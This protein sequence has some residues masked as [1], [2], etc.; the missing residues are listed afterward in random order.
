MTW[1]G[2]ESKRNKV[3]EEL[4]YIEDDI[5]SVQMPPEKCMK[6]RV[7][8]GPNGSTNVVV[9]NTQTGHQIVLEM[10]QAELEVLLEGVKDGFLCG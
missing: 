9:K 4:I 2:K 5:I 3:L 10:G 6:V 7:E 8:C 1:I